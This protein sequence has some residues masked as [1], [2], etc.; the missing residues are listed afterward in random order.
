M[1]LTLVTG[2]ARSGK[3]DW[4]EAAAASLDLPVTFV[5]TAEALD[6]DMAGRIARHRAGRPPAWTTIEAP[7][8]AAEAVRA[9]A[10]PVV[11]LDCLTLLVSNALLGD[12][13]DGP[14]EPPA[15]AARAAEAAV[16]AEVDALLEARAARDGHLIVVT[17]EVGL[18]VVPATPLGRTFRDALGAANR[19]LARE[20]DAVVLMVSGIALPLRGTPPSVGAN[21]HPVG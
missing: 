16:R 5:A 14:G 6:D 9:A 10:T 2:G 21:G 17:N 15:A 8:A 7:R 18:G 12:G 11:L 19:D 4:A 1:H 3:S 20:A 13:A